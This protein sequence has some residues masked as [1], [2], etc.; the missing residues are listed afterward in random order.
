L[1]SVYVALVEDNRRGDPTAPAAEWLLD[2][3]HVVSGAVRGVAH[4]LPPGFFRRLPSIAADEFA[5]MPRINA[6]ALELIRCSAGHLDGQRLH[7]FITAF[8]SVTPLTIGEL[9][10]WPSALKLALVEHLRTR[11]DIL[12][13][14]R[15]HRQQADL[16]AKA[17][18]KNS[19][20][21]ERWP[22][23]LHPALVIRL[24][25]HSREAGAA[26]ALSQQLAAALAKRG[27]TLEDAIRSEGRHQAAEQAAMANLVGSLRLIASFDWSEFFE[28]VSLVEHVLKRDPAGVYKRM[29]FQSRDRYRHA[30]EELA[31]PTG[32][33]QLRVALKSVERARQVAEQSPDARG[34]HVG[35]YLIGTARRHFER[36]VAWVP[37][38]RQ[39]L[40]RLVFACATPAYLGSIAIGTILLVA[41][42]LVYADAHGGRV[43]M[44]LIVVLT[45]IPASELTIQ[46]VQHV[47]SRL[48]APRRLPR[49]DFDRIPPDGHCADDLRQRRAGP[50][51]SSSSRGS[52]AWQRRSASPFRGP[53]RFSR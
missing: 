41:G 46:V 29:D 53:Q 28:S 38:L 10:A 36:S 33:A 49:L 50:R 3:F 48:I 19:A 6:L 40:Q 12:A 23:Q 37:G 44:L 5:G 2:N 13:A 35:E 4:D 39:R 17:L 22:D 14:T 30:V 16:L 20:A 8:Q 27:Q 51:S 11:A 45:V 24:L 34:A 1:R 32:E 31:E 15:V 18:E 47:I 21:P 25:Q 42:A 7:R 52:G 43:A 9:W 26:A